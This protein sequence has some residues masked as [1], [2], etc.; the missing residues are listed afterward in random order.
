MDIEKKLEERK[1]EVMS[2]P[3]QTWGQ[4]IFR[5][6]LGLLLIGG[7]LFFLTGCSTFNQTHD[8]KI[9]GGDSNSVMIACPKAEP[10]PMIIDEVTKEC[11]KTG[12]CKYA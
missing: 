5:A 12:E 10:V 4:F 2:E 8:C 3:K 11:I 1:Y 9:V 6:L 7:A